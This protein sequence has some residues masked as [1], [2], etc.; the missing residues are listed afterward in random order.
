[1]CYKSNTLLNLL[2][3]LATAAL[4]VITLVAEVIRYLMNYHSYDPHTY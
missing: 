4:P 1:M 3:Y 2:H